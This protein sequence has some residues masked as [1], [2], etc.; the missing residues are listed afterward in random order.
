MPTSESIYDPRNSLEKIFRVSI[1]GTLN[2]LGTNP[3]AASSLLVKH[4]SALLYMK[5]MP[6][7]TGE[8]DYGDPSLGYIIGARVERTENDFPFD[9]GFRSDALH[10]NYVVSDN[11]QDPQY[12]FFVAPKAT[13]YTPSK[14]AAVIRC[15]PK[16]SDDFLA[17]YGSVTP[18]S[19][20]IGVH[21][22]HDSPGDWVI[23]PNSPLVHILN[24]N[25]MDPVTGKPKFRMEPLERNKKLKGWIVDKVTLEK[26]Q[27]AFHRLILPAVAITDMTKLTISAFRAGDAWS[28][29]IPGL[30]NPEI[31][32]T[33]F[34]VVVY[35]K[36]TYRLIFKSEIP[37]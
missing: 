16:A 6:G 17:K 31:F 27:R 11:T 32:D 26:A 14:S 34:T 33:A 29:P 25:N 37:K 23:P 21:E 24:K 12:G 5:S 4:H 7:P 30:D 15:K 10:G 1:T 35:L 3:E 13:H 8:P 28:D 18:E 9:V 36:L 19:A 22:L 20:S 2:S